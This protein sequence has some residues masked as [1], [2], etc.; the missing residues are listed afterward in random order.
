MPP[1]GGSKTQ[2]NPCPNFQKIAQNTKTE[3]HNGGA[4]WRMDEGG[5]AMSEDGGAGRELVGCKV[6]GTVQWK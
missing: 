4:V 5:A 6:L 2:K 3:T 1:Q